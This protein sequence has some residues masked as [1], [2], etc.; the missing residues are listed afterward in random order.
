MFATPS[1]NSVGL[2][3]SVA[4]S[5]VAI[6]NFALF[7]SIAKIRLAFLVFAAWTQAKPTAPSPNT[8]TVAPSWTL[9]V[10]QTAPNPVLI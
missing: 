3:Q 5:I 1:G 6:S 9:Q 2:M 10:F 4:P 8:A 7:M